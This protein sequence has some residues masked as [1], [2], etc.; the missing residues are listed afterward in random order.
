MHEAIDAG[1]KLHEGTEGGDADHF[2]RDHGT[3][4]VLFGGHIPGLGL[5]LLETQLD[6]LALGVEAEDLHVHF[7][8]G[9]N[10][11]GRMLDVRPAQV[12]HMNQAIH[13]A[14]I[15]EGAEI[16]Q[17]A[18]AAVH[19]I[20]F[21]Q[22]GPGFGLLRGGFLTHHGA[23]AGHDAALLLIHLDDLELEGLAHEIADL[24]N[25]AVGEL[26]RRHEGANAVDRA[27][28]AALDNLFAHAL[29]ILVVLVL[30]D[31][32][33][34]GLAVQ[35]VA[36][37]QQNVTFAVVYLDDLHFDFVAQFDIFRHQV[38]ALDQPVALETDVDTDFVVGDL[39]HGALYGLPGPDLDQSRFHISHKAVL[40]RLLGGNLPVQLFLVSH[41]CDNLLK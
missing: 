36:L 15:H 12:G 33:R 22:A 9:R 25:V 10:D 23:A 41:A 40:F 1:L 28:Q 27:N 26:R 8:I 20:A 31:K 32:L 37:R 14:Q 21:M 35:D 3:G 4:G 38:L 30:L 11:L 5:Q 18:H 2:A 34:E 24:F 17:A 29:D 19:D 39:H 16:G 13:A 6:A 7:L